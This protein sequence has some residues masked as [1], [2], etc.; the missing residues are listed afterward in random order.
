M[1]KKTMTSPV[2]TLI[3]ARQILGNDKVSYTTIWKWARDGD[4]PTV[5]IGKRRFILR[6]PF[7]ALLKPP[8]SDKD[9]AA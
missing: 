3:E 4:L 8:P 1:K 2:M 7:L 5:K 9:C 6:E